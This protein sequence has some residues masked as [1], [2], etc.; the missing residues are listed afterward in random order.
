M[1]LLLSVY[2]GLM[3]AHQHKV[4]GLALRNTLSCTKGTAQGFC[5]SKLVLWTGMTWTLTLKLHPQEC[6]CKSV[7]FVEARPTKVYLFTGCRAIGGLRL[8]I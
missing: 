6:C 5:Y 8:I 4:Q 3:L 1:G 7:Y 2:S